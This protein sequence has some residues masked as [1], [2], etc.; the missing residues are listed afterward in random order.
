MPVSRRFPCKGIWFGYDNGQKA[1]EMM[2]VYQGMLDLY[3]ITGDKALLS[4]TTKAVEQIIDEEINIAGAG[5]MMECWSGGP[6]RHAL[7]PT[8]W[9]PA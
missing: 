9:R 2:S 3:D 5:S 6:I 8:R 1:Y 4:G 7:R